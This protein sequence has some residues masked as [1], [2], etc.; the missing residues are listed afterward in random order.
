[1]ICFSHRIVI[2]KV[3]IQMLIQVF[4]IVSGTEQALKQ[5]EVSVISGIKILILGEISRKTI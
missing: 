4:R 2:F 5:V 3:L 1:M